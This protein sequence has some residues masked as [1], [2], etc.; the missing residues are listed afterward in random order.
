M[1]GT[2][3]FIRVARCW[4]L[5]GIIG[6]YALLVV[7]H[8][9]ALIVYGAVQH[10]DIKNLNLSQTTLGSAFAISVVALFFAVVALCLTFPLY[11]VPTPVSEKE[12]GVP[13]TDLKHG[14]ALVVEIAEDS[15]S[16]DSRRIVRQTIQADEGQPND[17]R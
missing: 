8:V 15:L 1:K 10:N 11:S 13:A 9:I 12:S 4:C 16:G 3:G 6:L 7:V 14:T 17:I 5:Y 2:D